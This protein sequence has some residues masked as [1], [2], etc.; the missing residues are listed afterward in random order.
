MTFTPVDVPQLIKDCLKND[1]PPDFP[2][3]SVV[4]EFPADWTLGSD[5]VLV[6]ADDGGTVWKASTTTAIRMTSWTSGRDRTYVHAAVA[7]LLAGKIPGVAAIVP[8]SVSGVLESRDEST[9]GDLASVIVRARAR[10]Q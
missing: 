6:I 10:T 1:L 4:L 7:R 9:G 2:E 5:P 3:L 8:G